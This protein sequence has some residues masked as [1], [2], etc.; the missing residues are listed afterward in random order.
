MSKT[1]IWTIIACCL[2]A[3]APLAQGQRK[4]GLWE[5]TSSMSMSGM[6]AMPNMGSQ[7]QQVCVTQAMIDKYGGPYTNPQSAQCQ[8]TNVSLT[9]SGMTAN[10]T[11]SGRTNMTGTIQTTFVDANTT[12]TTM[13]LS[14]AMPTGQAMTM[15]MNSTSVYKGADC[16]SVK[17][18][19]MPS[20]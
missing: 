14:M 2:I 12:K 5:I 13:N 7:T 1:R 16:G 15:T 8:V 6:P 17:P 18:L 20:N 11:C 10:L 4:A 9:A 19:P 3:L